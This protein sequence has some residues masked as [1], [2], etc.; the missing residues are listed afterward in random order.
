MAITNGLSNIGPYCN[1]VKSLTTPLLSNVQM[2][3]YYKNRKLISCSELLDRIENEL[4]DEND[5]PLSFIGN[6]CLFIGFTM[7]D[8]R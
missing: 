1:I 3:S 4:K 6:F 7:I 8:N 2:D 5:D